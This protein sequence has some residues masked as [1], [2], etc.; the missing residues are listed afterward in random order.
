MRILFAPDY[1][2]TDGRKRNLIVR[3]HVS[4]R[5]GQLV[6]NTLV[7]PSD[8]R[9]RAG[10]ATTQ[11]NAA[12]RGGSG[13]TA[14][15]GKIPVAAR[16]SLQSGIQP[17]ANGRNR[18]PINP[19]DPAATV[20]KLDAN[21]AIYLEVSFSD[22]TRSN[23]FDYKEQSASNVVFDDR[24]GDPNDL[25]KVVYWDVDNNP[26]RGKYA[27][28]LTSTGNGTGTATL[29]V[30]IREEWQTQDKP[31]AL[32]AHRPS[33]LSQLFA[34]VAHVDRAISENERRRRLWIQ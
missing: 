9:A 27:A 17:G 12:N 22:G 6:A 28:Q 32:S 30:S 24:S 13:N 31:S 29:N 7:E 11:H 33:Q 25:I 20:D 34:N 14:S 2:D 15:T 8:C 19:G 23:A 5:N 1:C 18:L 26:A 10:A 4:D 21:P 16:L 3:F